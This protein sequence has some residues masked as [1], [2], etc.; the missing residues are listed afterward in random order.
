MELPIQ[1]KFFKKLEL[2][3]EYVAQDK[4]A[5]NTKIETWK[6]QKDFLRW[7]KRHHNVGSQLSSLSVR[8][9][10]EEMKKKKYKEYKNEDIHRVI[11]DLIANGYAYDVSDNNHQ[12][13]VT[14]EGFMMGEIIDDFEGSNSSFWSRRKYN[15]LLKLTWT[16]AI[17]A[18]LLIIAKFTSYIINLIL[19]L[20]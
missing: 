9:K 10:M 12:I 13:K 1:L 16:S 8:Q 7:T 20:F 6:V 5:D 19:Q 11:S 4:K 15:L 3:Q 14:R 17:C 18:A 2:Y